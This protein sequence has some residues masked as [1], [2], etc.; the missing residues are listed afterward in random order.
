[1]WQKGTSFLPIPSPKTPT[2]L[3]P[4]NKTSS[5]NSASHSY[6]KGFPLS[7]PK[8]ELTSMAI[9][10]A[11]KTTRKTTSLHLRLCLMIP[12][13]CVV[14]S[15][16]GYL[17]IIA[18]SGPPIAPPQLHYPEQ[19][20]ADKRDTQSSWTRRRR[21]RG[22][23]EEEE[24]KGGSLQVKEE[25]KVWGGVNTQNSSSVLTQIKTVEPGE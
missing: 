17:P 7:N 25:A 21:R 9:Q 11:I 24:G 22:R 4:T 10:K 20:T 8:L 1:M 6:L 14:P 3:K 5:K 15:L 19:P 2:K 18:P 16:D 23:T 12:P 13:T